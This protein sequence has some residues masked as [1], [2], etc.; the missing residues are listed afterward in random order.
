MS[1]LPGV[2]PGNLPV[3]FALACESMTVNRIHEKAECLRIIFFE[4]K[5]LLMSF[6]EIA[7]KFLSEEVGAIA[8]Q[9][10]MQ[11]PRLFLGPDQDFDELVGGEI[12]G[13]EVSDCQV[14]KARKAD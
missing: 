13:S 1:P 11:I 4:P 9:I 8:E 3:M 6:L 5:F 12:S 14:G 7:L 2:L 10:F